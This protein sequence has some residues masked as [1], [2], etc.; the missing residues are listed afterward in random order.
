M[1]Q[2]LLQ[3]AV[4]KRYWEASAQTKQRARPQAQATRDKLERPQ[5]DTGMRAPSVTP[6][7]YSY[8][9]RIGV[10]GCP[11]ERCYTQKGSQQG[12]LCR[13]WHGPCCWFA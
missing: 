2:H 9:Y 6:C 11:L 13:R 10:L 3:T 5:F 12:A 7:T 1:G 8:K 4:R